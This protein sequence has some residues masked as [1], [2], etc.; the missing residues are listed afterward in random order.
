MIRIDEY[1]FCPL[2]YDGTLNQGLVISKAYC[3]SRDI[4]TFLP[5]V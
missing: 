1:L 3:P 4:E 5:L 2:Y